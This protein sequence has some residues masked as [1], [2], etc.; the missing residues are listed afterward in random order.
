[1]H[2]AMETKVI[3]VNS[4]RLAT[5]DV[6]GRNNNSGFF[7][8]LRQRF[9]C[10][11]REQTFFPNLSCEVSINQSIRQSI[12]QS[13]NQSIS[14]SVSQSVNQSINQSINQSFFYVLMYYLQLDCI[15]LYFCLYL[16]RDVALIIPQKQTKISS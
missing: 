12:N 15:S 13:I 11:G 9:Q 14:Q 10:H 1:M 7:V 4:D 6:T 5:H 3:E 8:S 2:S 16:Q